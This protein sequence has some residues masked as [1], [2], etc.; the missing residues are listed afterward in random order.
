MKFYKIIILL[1]LPLLAIACK[2]G[3]NSK[4]VT[5]TVI[6]QKAAY[7]TDDPTIWVNIKDPS[8]SL[9]FGTDKGNDNPKG[10]ALLAYNLMGKNIPE[11]SIHGLN[12]PNNVDLEYGMLIE[13]VATDIIALTERGKSQIRIFAVPSMEPLDDGGIPVFEGEKG[14]MRLPMGIALFRR[15]EDKSI[16][17][18]VSRKNG[19]SGS[20]LWQYLLKPENG[21]IKAECIRKFGIFEGDEIEAIAVDDELGYV[22]YSDEGAGVRKYYA[23]P[24]KSNK[25]LACFGKKDF[26][27]DNEGISIYTGEKGS[28]YILVSDQQ[29][30]RFNIYTRQ[31]SKTNPH[32]HKLIKSVE[33]ATKESDGS[34]VTSYPLGDTFSHGLF[35]AMSDDKTFQYYRWEDIA[36][37]ELTK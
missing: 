9:I 24:K 1:L 12:R 25:E 37:K 36:G 13:G 2:Q 11:K 27:K 32:D 22:Y 35:V 14:D 15:P 18:I 28:G 26:L 19:E 17:C 30:N 33:T 21:M 16:F 10:G 7:D 4:Q 5:P 3:N 34:E 8:K 6:T 23:D 20:Y 29:A 31:G